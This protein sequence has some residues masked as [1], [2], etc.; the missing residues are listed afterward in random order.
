[1]HLQT[2]W[3]A[4][5]EKNPNVRKI[6]NKATPSKYI[7]TKMLLTTPTL[8]LKFFIASTTKETHPLPY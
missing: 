4:Y 6:A 1:M 7:R 2:K 3:N 5:P 8:I